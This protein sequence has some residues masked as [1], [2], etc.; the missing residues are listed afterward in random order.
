MFVLSKIVIY[1]SF[2]EFETHITT[3][4]KSGWDYNYFSMLPVGKLKVEWV[5]KSAWR[6][7]NTD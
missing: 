6:I 2:E 3:M 1:D 5:D 7:L 4:R